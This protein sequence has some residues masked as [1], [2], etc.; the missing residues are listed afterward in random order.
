MQPKFLY[1]GNLIGITQYPS[2]LLAHL[3]CILSENKTETFPVY[4]R[5][6]NSSHMILHK[7]SFTE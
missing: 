5:Y 3:E 1:L 7:K 6:F 4:S 2:M